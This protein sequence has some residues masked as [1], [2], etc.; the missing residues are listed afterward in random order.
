MNWIKRKVLE[1]VFESKYIDVIRDRCKSLDNE[2]AELNINTHN[3]INKK[4]AHLEEKIEHSNAM[5]YALA[6]YM[7]CQIVQT[8]FEDSPLE[9]EVFSNKDLEALKEE[10]N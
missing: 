8:N 3:L 4:H 1:W 9:Y 2:I 7:N 10:G 5:L 6:D